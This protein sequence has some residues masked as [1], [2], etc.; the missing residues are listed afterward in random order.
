MRRTSDR[1]SPACGRRWREAPDEGAPG[2]RI[3]AASPSAPAAH[4]RGQEAQQRPATAVQGGLERFV[5]GVASDAPD[6]G[7]PVLDT[8][9]NNVRRA[10]EAT[11]RG[12]FVMYDIARADPDHWAETIEADWRRLIASGV[13]ASPAYQR[14]RGRPV[15]AIAD[16][17]PASRRRRLGD[18]QLERCRTW[19]PKSWTCLP[20]KPKSARRPH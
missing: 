14:H 20:L 15:L 17:F 19:K 16:T 6:H 12:F 5:V 3:S 1:P 7:R 11:G 10:A 9:L 2:D 8:V 4:G 13:V 18:V